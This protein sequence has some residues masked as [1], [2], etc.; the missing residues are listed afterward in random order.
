MQNQNN[1]DINQNNQFNQQ[2]QINQLNNQYNPYLNF[3][4][5]QNIP[6]PE[7]DE[8]NQNQIPPQLPPQV[9]QNQ[10][11]QIQV[12]IQIPPQMQI[13]QPPVQPV[14]VPQI[15]NN[16][17]NVNNINQE[18]EIEIPQFLNFLCPNCFQ[19]TPTIDFLEESKEL[20]ILIN[21]RNCHFN[22]KKSFKD[23][24]PQIF[25]KKVFYCQKKEGAHSN[26]KAIGVVN[27]K[28]YC[29]EC[30]QTLKAVDDD[31]KV[32]SLEIKNHNNLEKN[33]KCN[34]HNK[35]Y[36]YYCENCHKNLCDLCQFAE[37]NDNSHLVISLN[38]LFS[39]LDINK[40][41]NAINESENFIKKTLPQT[42]TRIILSIQEIIKQIETNY[43]LYI[44]KAEN[45]IKIYKA[46]L[47]NYKQ[48]S[49]TKEY[50]KNI[51]LANGL[52]Y[53]HNNFSGRFGFFK[54]DL[55]NI[56]TSLNEIKI[57]SNFLSKQLVKVSG[58]E[59]LK[60]FKN[61]LILTT[62]EEKTK[63]LQWLTTRGN[64]KQ[65]RLIYKASR[66]GDDSQNFH[67]FCDGKGATLSLF[68]GMNGK[69]WG[70]FTFQDW[71]KGAYKIK[72]DPGAF[73]FSLD[74]RKRFVVKNSK[75]GISCGDG[76]AQIFGNK[77]S[78]DGFIVC[79]G[80]LKDKR[81]MENWRTKNYEIDNFTLT[82]GEWTQLIDN[83]CYQV[84]F[85]N[86]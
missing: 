32:E 51:N 15:M 83:E 86:L 53:L 82:G 64:I 78:R 63:I 40:I 72:S 52:F 37:H 76:F 55:S 85:D 14:Q 65:L 13:Q 10:L 69:K 36:V 12:Q 34:I 59:N 31:I 68:K 62:T 45:F 60:F 2:N 8:I 74:Y 7:L 48:T 28:N 21:C 73:L 39:D 44:E 77:G 58:E 56:T 57:F 47:E 75:Y 81:C 17:N 23:Y 30:I 9:P 42:K 70:G 50:D 24:I 26:I 19:L 71:E 46:L 67:R 6:V 38:R 27:G 54:Y 41:N 11:P 66:D 3:P 4:L 29:A 1:V 5:K 33:V 20:Y 80:F 35:K 49:N 16:I 61:S 84:I 25:E 22:S 18:V 43:K 79:S